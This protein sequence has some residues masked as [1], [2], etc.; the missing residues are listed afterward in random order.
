MPARPG[1]G[2][3]VFL[4]TFAQT[5]PQPGADELLARWER[6]IE[7]RRLVNKALESARGEIGKSLEAAVTIAA[8]ASTCSFLASF[9][10][11]LKDVLIVSSVAVQEDP[12]AAAGPSVTVARAPG[13]KCSRCWCWSTRVGETPS[14]PEVCPRCAGALAV[15]GA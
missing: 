4:E 8:D 11:L 14:H 9:G 1:K 15:I 3:S 12:A 13:S 6:L 2:E 7:T 10:D 5:P